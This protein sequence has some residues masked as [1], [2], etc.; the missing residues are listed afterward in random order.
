[1][2]DGALNPLRPSGLTD[3]HQLLEWRAHLVRT[4]KGDC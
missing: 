4:S 3:A 1:M 2:I